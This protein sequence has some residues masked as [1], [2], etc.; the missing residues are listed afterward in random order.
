M[1]RHSR[2][3][4]HIKPVFQFARN[5]MICFFVCFFGSYLV[6]WICNGSH[7]R[8]RYLGI[9]RLNPKPH[10]A[11]KNHSL[12]SSHSELKGQ[13]YLC[14][15]IAAK[16]KPQISRTEHLQFKKTKQ[17]FCEVFEILGHIPKMVEQCRR[18][19]TL[20]QTNI[21]PQKIPGASQKESS[22]PSMF[23]GYGSFLG[24]ISST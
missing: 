13:N 9:P 12:N 5:K 4:R 8:D 17:Q 24:S 14:S 18:K 23:R 3:I 6:V 7:E 16:Q 20:P 10:W 2:N 22:L 11:K 21:A 19:T 1:L 15:N